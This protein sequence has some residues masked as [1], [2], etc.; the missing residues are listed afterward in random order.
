MCA[1]GIYLLI[2]IVLS[3]KLQ[4]LAIVAWEKD[5]YS[6]RRLKATMYIK[7]VAEFARVLLLTMEMTF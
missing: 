6:R 7:D 1:S 2:I 4:V 3:D 5:L